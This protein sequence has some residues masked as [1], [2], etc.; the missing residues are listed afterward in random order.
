MS[1]YFIYTSVLYFNYC[2][3]FCFLYYSSYIYDNL[4]TILVPKGQEE[5]MK[6]LGNILHGLPGH[7]QGV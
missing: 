1:F 5:C 6:N 2:F 3:I 7:I 4:Y